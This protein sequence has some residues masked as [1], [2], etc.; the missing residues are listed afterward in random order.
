[1]SAMDDRGTPPG[2]DAAQAD[3]DVKLDTGTGGPGE[4][5]AG[6][7]ST[8]P[9]AASPSQG[10]GLGDEALVEMVSDPDHQA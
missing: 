7:T 6:R 2:V 10:E 9:G 3:G 1:M 5:M 8:A 4:A